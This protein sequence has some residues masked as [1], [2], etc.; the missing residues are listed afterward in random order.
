MSH[1]EHLPWAAVT[2]SLKTFKCVSIS[3]SLFDSP[4][5]EGAV[6]PSYGP[7]KTGIGD[8][9]TTGPSVKIITI[10]FKLYFFSMPLN[11]SRPMNLIILNGHS[12]PSYPYS[13]FILP[14]RVSSTDFQTIYRAMR[15]E[16][17]IKPKRH[18]SAMA[19]STSRNGDFALSP[20]AILGTPY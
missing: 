4:P 20:S 10:T 15:K 11:F 7:P 14:L 2:C 18:I 13:D 17:K 19:S 1:I 9:G 16:S 5:S 8:P 3:F 6:K 12:K